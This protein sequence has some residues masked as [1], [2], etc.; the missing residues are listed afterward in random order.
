MG[1]YYLALL[2]IWF[3]VLWWVVKGLTW[4]LD[5]RYKRLISLIVIVIVYPLPLA[6]EIIGAIQFSKLCEHQVIYKDPDMEKKRGARLIFDPHE[7]R[8]IEGKALP[9]T[10][11]LWE[12][13]NESDKS[14]MLSYVVF[15]TGQGRLTRHAQL[16]EGGSPLI[17]SG[18][19]YPKEDKNL[20]IYYKIVN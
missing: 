9:M 12:F 1:L 4:R 13:V 8:Q 7:K 16:N 11:E 6:D 5:H 19:C 10:S 3:G 15:N 18:V 17:F 14:V 20:Y 2:L